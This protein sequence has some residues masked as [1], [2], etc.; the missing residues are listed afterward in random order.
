MNITKD[1]VYA[2]PAEEKNTCFGCIAE[3]NGALCELLDGCTNIIYKL[4]PKFDIKLEIE[5]E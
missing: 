1:M 2:V 5:N 4:N 3:D